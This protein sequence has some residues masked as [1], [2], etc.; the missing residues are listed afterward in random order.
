M[1]MLSPPLDAGKARFMSC[2]VVYSLRVSGFE[3]F[4]WF[5]WVPFGVFGG[6]GFSRVLS[7]V[8]FCFLCHFC[9]L[10]KCLGVPTLFI[11]LI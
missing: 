9:I 1:A 11:E 8:V 10:P 3:G 7:L 5:C 6:V 2:N 4:G